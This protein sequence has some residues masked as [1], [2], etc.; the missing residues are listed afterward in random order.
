MGSLLL[1]Q[2]V[3]AAGEQLPDGQGLHT[4]LDGSL[5]VRL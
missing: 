1:S 3:A 5:A 2:D 4:E